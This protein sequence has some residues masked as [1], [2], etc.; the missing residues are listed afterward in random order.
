MSSQG[1][2]LLNAADQA[3]LLVVGDCGIGGLRGQPLGAVSIAMLLQAPCPVAVTHP[4]RE[5]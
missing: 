4:A 1:Q 3:G 5:E 2:A